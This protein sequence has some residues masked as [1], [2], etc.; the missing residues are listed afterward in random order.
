M[1]P[2]RGQGMCAGLRDAANVC[3][4]VALAAKTL[5]T[6]ASTGSDVNP[7]SPEPFLSR[8]LDTY[9]AE[10]RPHWRSTTDIAIAIGSL[11]QLRRPSLLLFARN[12]LVGGLYRFPLTQP[13]FLAPFAPPSRMDSGWA[14]WHGHDGTRQWANSNGR[15]NIISDD[16][17]AA[18]GVGSKIAS[19]VLS[20]LHDGFSLQPLLSIASFA[21]NSNSTSSSG[22][23]HS[24]LPGWASRDAGTGASVPNYPVETTSVDGAAVR[25]RLDQLLQPGLPA[26]LDSS[27]PPL[28]HVIVSPALSSDGV[29]SGAA[30]EH[31]LRTLRRLREG[32]DSP[33]ECCIGL[34]L[35]PT[36]AAPSRIAAHA[37]YTARSVVRGLGGVWS[38]SVARAAY[39]GSVYGPVDAS[40][41]TTGSEVQ[42]AVAAGKQQLQAS[43]SSA[44]YRPFGG[45]FFHSTSASSDSNSNVS[46]AAP[47]GRK[48]GSSSNGSSGG[49]GDVS[50]DGDWFACADVAA[51]DSSG[52]LSLWLA[53]HCADVAIVRPDR[54]VY[55]LY[56]ACEVEG[57]LC[58]LMMTL[59]PSSTAAGDDP[60]SYSSPAS[61]SSS[62]S[63][64]PPS[65]PSSMAN[66]SG[67][68]SAQLTL[69]RSSLIR[70]RQVEGWMLWLRAAVAWLVLALVARALAVVAVQAGRR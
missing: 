62:S 68:A 11:V 34:Q 29:T 43:S 48:T 47:L 18:I 52:K 60:H 46:V 36:T 56:R 44:V 13:F 41:A 25:L 6:A 15:S 21:F 26:G 7:A 69:P 31:P 67:S 50:E 55:G 28:W 65:K 12:L 1:P 39:A 45:D 40:R 49:L 53:H 14:D 59:T 51:A 33:L 61:S 22:G 9:Q 30:V 63:F 27:R 58:N 37:S 19:A 8:V 2:F 38:P 35:L 42:A 54:V 3:W 4:K 17:S 32:Q 70:R 24:A 66:S 5:S 10:R 57:A 20:G 64:L 16:D 23:G